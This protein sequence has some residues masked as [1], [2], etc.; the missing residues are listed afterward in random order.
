MGVAPRHAYSSSAHHHNVSLLGITL[1]HPLHLKLI[2]LVS[3]DKAELS[4]ILY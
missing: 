1:S 2:A 4:T 3:C